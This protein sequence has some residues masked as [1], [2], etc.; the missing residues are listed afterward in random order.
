MS[1]KYFSNQFLNI[2]SEFV[3]QPPKTKNKHKFSR[4]VSYKNKNLYNKKNTKYTIETIGCH[5]EE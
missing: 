5:D 3:I 1:K 4:R 2:C